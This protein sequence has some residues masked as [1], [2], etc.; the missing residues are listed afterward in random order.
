M[1]PRSDTH[2]PAARCGA[3]ACPRMIARIHDAD[4]MRAISVP[5]LTDLR[6]NTRL[7][8]LALFLAGV[9]APPL[10]ADPWLAPGDLTTR[11]DLSLLA[12]AGILRGPITTW[13]ISWPDVARDVNT[14]RLPD[15]ASP[16][17][18][19]ALLRVQSAARREAR[20]GFDG[21]GYRVS[22]A[23]DPDLLRTFSD[24]PREEGELELR[25]SWMGD[26]L[27]ANLQVTGVTDASDG[28][29]ARF[30]GSYVGLNV[31]N[32]MI[33]AGWM[34]RWWGP[35]WEGSLILGTSARPIPSLRIERNYTDA[36]GT[37]WLSWLGPW[38]ASLE[39]GQAEGSDVPVPD[40]RFLAARLNFK[41]LPW[42]E[43]GLSRTA[44]WC[45]EGRP[46]GW[47]T[48][49]DLLIGNDNDVDETGGVSQ[50]PGNQMAGYDFRL[51]SPW[52][53]LPVAVYG[54]FIGE[55]EAGKLPAKFLGQIGAETWFSTPLGGLRAHLE[56]SDTT[57]NFT[58]SEPIYD[59]AY[60]N[61]LFPQGYT[62]RSRS[63]GHA[64][65]NDGRMYSVGALLVRPGG[66]SLSLL[67]RKVDLNR[68]GTAPDMAH[69]I[70]SGPNELKNLELQY[71]R[72][73][74][75][76]ELRLGLGY[77]DYEIEP[78]DGSDVTGFI[79]WRQGF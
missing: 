79:E 26:R 63:I 50:Q 11:H 31:G 20:S 34:E 7:A 21:L 22:G 14:A 73:F 6:Q 74:P 44:Q 52:R 77:N 37:R 55:D 10:H 5:A 9:A 17:L 70:S 76:G 68:G 40:V 28:Q 42:F 29:S 19:Q 49:W 35:G 43:F 2:A 32:F 56:Y 58:R 23:H 15:D 72:P 45:G 38:R 59:C 24:T 39:L 54:Q 27:A 47:G 57:C 65:D 8:A 30:D 61:G 3:P 46:C 36:F 25:A 12:D 18:R 33:S 71:N 60:R 16:A 66:D 53:S 48:F 41:P 78:E 64:M 69:T 75:R 13:P 67:A 62:F 4:R 51:S 1:Y